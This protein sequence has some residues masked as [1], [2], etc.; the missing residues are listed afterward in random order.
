MVESFGKRCVV[1]KWKKILYVELKG[2]SLVGT[3]VR[4]SYTKSTSTDGG[5]RS[6]LVHLFRVRVT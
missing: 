6:V 3:E 1:N 4:I 5:V 2:D